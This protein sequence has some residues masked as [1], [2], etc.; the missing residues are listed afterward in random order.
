[1]A[2]FNSQ[3]TLFMYK[4][5]WGMLLQITV[6]FRVCDIWRGYWAQRLLWDIG[7]HLSF[8][9]PNAVQFRN[10]HNYLADFIDE[11]MLYHDAGRLVEFLVN[12]KS[13]KPDFFSRV[14]DLSVAMVEKG[15][16]EINEAILT[17]AWLTDLVSIGYEM[18]A[19]KPVQRPCRNTLGIETELRS[20]EKSSAYLRADRS[21][22]PPIDD[23]TVTRSLVSTLRNITQD[24][25]D[26][27]R[28]FFATMNVQAHQDSGYKPHG[29]RLVKNW[30]L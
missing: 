19:V 15:F 13:G 11:K 25:G 10:A 9:P 17:E 8:F 14:L 22:T 28:W 29:Y 27:I 12:W 16:W 4:A 7:S 3:N 18:P 23:R 30:I 20:K 5:L 6:A 21:I 24:G 26:K 2:P 1:M